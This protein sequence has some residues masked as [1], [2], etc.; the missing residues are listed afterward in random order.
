MLLNGKAP[1]PGQIITL[2]NLAKTFKE[3]VAK[4]KDGFYKGRIAQA[5]VDLIKSK[6]GKMELEDLANHTS[7]I[8]EPIKYTYAN[9]VT[10]YEVR[11]LNDN[12][13]V[14]ISSQFF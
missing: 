6:G 13:G 10:L 3:V 5:I 14:H 2:P 9:D 8:V 1:L 12:Y 4:G 7:S 11:H